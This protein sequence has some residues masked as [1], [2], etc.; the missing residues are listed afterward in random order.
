MQVGNAV[1]EAFPL[2]VYSSFSAKSSSLS[3][4]VQVGRAEEKRSRIQK[5]LQKMMMMVVF[6]GGK[7]DD[8]L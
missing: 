4:S 2:F 7:D 8:R 6:T 5:A 1:R 3:A